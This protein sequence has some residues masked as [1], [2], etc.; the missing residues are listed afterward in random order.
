MVVLNEMFQQLHCVL[1]SSSLNADRTLFYSCSGLY[2]CKWMWITLVSSRE[3]RINTETQIQTRILRLL[4]TLIYAASKSP[5][6]G[7]VFRYQTQSLWFFLTSA[8]FTLSTHCP[9]T[10]ACCIDS[11]DTYLE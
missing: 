7:Q 2:R 8:S 3:S 10:T 11:P 1:F 6:P 9:S 5:N 4:P